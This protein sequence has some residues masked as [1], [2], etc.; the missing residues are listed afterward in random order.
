M[1]LWNRPP[2]LP[3]LVAALVLAGLVALVFYPILGFEF[4]NL[5]V[6]S[7][8]IN[9][10]YI[11]GFSSANVWHILT[12]PCLESYYPVR[13]L[14]YAL[15][16]SI[17][18]LN[19]KGFKLTNSLI[20]LT[21]VLLLAWLV[22]RLVGDS[23]AQEESRHLWREALVATFAAGVFAIHPVVVQSVAWV[24]GRE[25][26]L[27]TLGALACIHFHLS[28]RQAAAA[29]SRPAAVRAWHALAA[30]SCL[31]ACLSNVVGIVVPAFV[32][33]W[34]WLSLPSPRLGRT[35]RGSLAMW[36]I[37]VATLMS[38]LSRWGIEPES[39]AYVA[40]TLPSPRWLLV[41]DV[42]WLNV[43]SLIQPVGLAISYDNMAFPQGYFDR[44]VV[45]G[46]LAAGATCL[47]LWWLRHER[48]ALFG[49]L[50]FLI[51][52]APAAQIMPN[53]ILRADR[54]LYLPLAGLA[55]VLA[56]GVESWS[57]SRMLRRRTS[58]LA[59]TAAGSGIL[60]ALAAA[61]AGYVQ[62]WRNPVTVWENSVGVTPEDSYQHDMLADALQ[63][64][65]AVERAL[66]HSLRSLELD[67]AKNPTGL[68]NRALV[69]TSRTGMRLVDRTEAVRLAGRACE[70]TG[71]KDPQC[72]RILAVSYCSLADAQAAAG[73]IAAARENYRK[74]IEQDGQYELALLNLALLL[75]T[76]GD[77]G[78]RDPEEAVRLA[79]RACRLMLNPSPDA[80]RVLAEAYYAA[81][82]VDQATATAERVIRIVERSGD[83]V[84]L[85]SVRQWIENHQ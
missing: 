51:A 79:E 18:G 84:M 28:A 36:A 43:N 32:V 71:W 61:S 22:H 45:L 7:S 16:Y 47:L 30:V 4:I 20:H 39:S 1:N 76:S 85:E 70:L 78:V 66:Y 19:P 62:T 25:E 8:V 42:Y 53:H 72:R 34:D 27:M 33:V 11:R 5:D 2:R 21:N 75:T 82:R 64:C 67:F 29:G 3:T 31:V 46:G 37:A 80:L 57:R 65:G 59:A 77:P 38:K 10:P 52:L 74:A 81:G 60:F 55:V 26:L 68:C 49:M 83:K 73:Q 69:L 63:D 48:T 54:F 44:E 58:M 56:A 6:D 17:W 13:T 9:N 41:L 14:T 15:D 50:W 23:A 24:P 35:I 12:T 40:P